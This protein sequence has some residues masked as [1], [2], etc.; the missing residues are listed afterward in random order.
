M[1]QP[2]EQ[3]KKPWNWGKRKPLVDDL[4]NKWCD[5]K[6]PKLTSNYGVRG[7]ALC[8]LCMNPW[9]R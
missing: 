6:E 9:Y 5:C 7:Q 1:N 8:L 3:S 4:G 2:I